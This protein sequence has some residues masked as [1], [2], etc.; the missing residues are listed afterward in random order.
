MTG[1]RLAFPTPVGMN[2]CWPLRRTKK[3]CVPHARGDEPADAR[4]I[5]GTLTAFH[6]P[7][8]MNRARQVR[9]IP[10]RRVPHARGDEPDKV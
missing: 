7:V 2:R 10:L 9:R 5:A 1:A 3:S 8:G 4:Q 6:A